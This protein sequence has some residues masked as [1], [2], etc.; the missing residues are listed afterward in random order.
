MSESPNSKHTGDA[1]ADAF[2]VTAIITI[3]VLTLY[4]W[5]SGMPS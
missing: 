3:V 5:L 4:V 2:A 1:A